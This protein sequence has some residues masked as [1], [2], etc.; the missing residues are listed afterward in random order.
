MWRKKCGS[1]ECYEKE[2]RSSVV[3]TK[4]EFEMIFKA[5]METE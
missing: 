3:V 2:K 4:N 1:R 5:D